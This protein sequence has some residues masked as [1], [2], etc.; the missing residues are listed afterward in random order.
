MI[1]EVTCDWPLLTAHRPPEGNRKNHKAAD[2]R[3][4]RACWRTASVGDKFVC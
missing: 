4:N 2:E 1:K 3:R